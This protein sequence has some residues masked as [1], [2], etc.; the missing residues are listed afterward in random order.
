MGKY[1]RNVGASAG[2]VISYNT[3]N[4]NEV[5][6]A[7][8]TFLISLT[9]EI[10]PTDTDLLNIRDEMLALVHKAQYLLTLN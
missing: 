8:E 9:N 5:I 7:F 4:V 1:G 2:S 10:Q 3:S 6:V